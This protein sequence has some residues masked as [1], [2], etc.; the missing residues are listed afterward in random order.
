MVR[1]RSRRDIGP[2]LRSTTS[3][4]ARRRAK[5]T[6]GLRQT[7]VVKPVKRR[8]TTGPPK[9]NRIFDEA[10]YGITAVTD[11][12]SGLRRLQTD[13][14]VHRRGNRWFLP[15]KRTASRL[16]EQLLAP[17][18]Q[19]SNYSEL[20]ATIQALESVHQ[21][22]IAG[23][24][25][26]HVIIKTDSSY[27][28]LGLSEHIW[29]WALNGFRNW[30]GQP[31]VNGRAFKYLHEKVVL[32]EKEY[33]IHVSFCLVKKEFNQQADGLARAAID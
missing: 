26:S 27:L 12:S 25:L 31:V 4:A 18:P 1:V 30:K 17:S 29:K 23:E 20:Y 8:V 14:A 7:R 19:T 2:L 33:G 22:I 15:A 24:D 5:T 3:G 11:E 10:R 21:L 13:P 32:L 9:S 28:A 16:R 6:N